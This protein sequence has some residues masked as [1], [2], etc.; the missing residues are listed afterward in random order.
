M[1]IVDI[2]RAPCIDLETRGYNAPMRQGS[3]PIPLLIEKHSRKPVEHCEQGFCGVGA[4]SAS[5]IHDRT[6][7]DLVNKSDVVLSVQSSLPESKTVQE[8]GFDCH[9][10]D[11]HMI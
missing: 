1:E 2:P 8:V 10:I 9:R 6:S 11:P 5:N 4:Q 7:S 3:K